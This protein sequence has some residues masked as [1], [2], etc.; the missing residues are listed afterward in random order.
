MRIILLLL[1]LLVGLSTRSTAADDTSAAQNVIRRQEQALARDDA[2]SAYAEAAPEIHALFPTPDIFMAMVKQGYAPVY[3]HKSFEFSETKTDGGGIA[4]R[5]RI[6][7]ANG[8]AWEALYLLE[9]QP[10]GSLK[11]TGCSLLKS[12]QSV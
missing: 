4:Q 10:D 9:Q 2:A 12:G 1:T 5:V 7:D 3:R 6:I 11:I 8:E